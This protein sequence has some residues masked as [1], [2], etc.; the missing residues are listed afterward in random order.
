MNFWKHV[1]IGDDIFSGDDFGDH[2][3]F[4]G[5]RYF[6]IYCILF[7]VICFL[8]L[9]FWGH[10]FHLSLGSTLPPTQLAFCQFDFLKHF[11]LRSFWKYMR[12]S[13]RKVGELSIYIFVRPTPQHHR[14]SDSPVGFFFEVK[15]LE[16]QVERLLLSC[17]DLP[18]QEKPLGC[19]PCWTVDPVRYVGWIPNSWFEG[20]CW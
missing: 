3:I 9:V 1:D 6:W 15:T 19:E 5:G 11:C 12:M 18:G 2:Y 4:W 13:L 14:A 8:G 16:N 17:Q 20:Q 10:F 7:G